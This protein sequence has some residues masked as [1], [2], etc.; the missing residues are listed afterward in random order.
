MHI[1]DSQRYEEDS[2]PLDKSE[3][4]YHPLSFSDVKFS[5]NAERTIHEAVERI[6]IYCERSP[7]YFYKKMDNEIYWLDPSGILLIVIHSK[8]LNADMYIEIPPGHWWIVDSAMT[9]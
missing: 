6:A 9:S 8:D 4:I 7:M 3:Q 2:D 5:K 1:I